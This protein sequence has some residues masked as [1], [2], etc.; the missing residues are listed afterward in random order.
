MGISNLVYQSFRSLSIVQFST[1]EINSFEFISLS[2]ALN[3]KFVEVKEVSESGS[4]NNLNVINHSEFFVFMSD[5]EILSG[6]KQN[7]VLNTS[8]LVSPKS[9]V[10]IPVS[11]VEQGRW[12]Y[13][14]RDFSDSDYSAPSYMRSSKAKSVKE[15]LKIKKSFSADQSKV[16]DN[17][18]NYETVFHM[19]SPTSNLSDIYENS[20]NDLNE[21]VK[22]FIPEKDSNGLAI[23]VHNKLLNLEIFNRTEIYAEYFIKLLKSAAF[24][25]ICMKDIENTLTEAE[26]F[27]KTNDF[28]DSISQLKFEAHKGVA[29]GIEKRFDTIDMTGFELDLEDKM[30]HFVSLNLKKDESK[31][32]TG[33]DGRKI[34]N[35]GKYKGRAI[36]DICRLNP[37]YIKWLCFDSKLDR[38]VKM[39][40]YEIMLRNNV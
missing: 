33:R 3:N 25:A 29:A 38:E 9:K 7:R 4:V 19:K 14:Q 39:E 40:I 6:A 24:E 12:R 36:D 10:K 34:L 31:I 26:A 37:E 15:N 23:F 21:F 11:C 13:S 35:F 22:N 32:L 20:E 1:D 27:Y 8:V 18:S 5:G 16:W 17:V 2:N 28:M 30:I